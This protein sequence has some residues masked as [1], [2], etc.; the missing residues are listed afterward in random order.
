MDDY[1][2]RVIQ[3][4]TPSKHY[5]IYYDKNNDPIT[6]KKE[7]K[8]I[9]ADIY[10]PPAYNNVKIYTDKSRDIRA[11]GSDN[12]DRPQ[13]IY[14]KSFTEKQ[15][16]KKYNHMSVFGRSFL[17][18]NRKITEDLYSVKDSKEKQIAIILKLI[19]DCH[20]RVGNE[21]YSKD[22]KS[23]GTTT[24]ENR[25]LK[26]KN[27]TAK[28]EFIGKKKVKNTCTIKNKK[29]VRTLKSKKKYSKK[30]DRLFTYRYKEKYYT[31]KPKDVNLYLKQFGPF[32]TKNFRTWGANI[33]LIKQLVKK[34]KNNDNKRKILRESICKVSEKLHNTPGV[35]KS[36]YLDP[37]LVSLYKDNP[38]KFLNHFDT[39]K[40]EE[41]Y[42]KYVYF[43]EGGL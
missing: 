36:N 16:D 40:K 9:C 35:C 30:N 1:I 6:N 33:E 37:S 38:K 2:T 42:K 34:S 31:V 3:R 15:S 23:Y 29:L 28:I 4:K 21:R 5:Y 32:T 13:Y 10:I 41:L 17:K 8:K 20:F 43:L 26:I 19:M 14:N 25:H 11:I 24:L 39:V 27:N 22:N 7:I 12:K 18:I